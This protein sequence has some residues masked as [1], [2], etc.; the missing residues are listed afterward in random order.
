MSESLFD[1]YLLDLSFF[2]LSVKKRQKSLGSL[3][4]TWWTYSKHFLCFLKQNILF[5]LGRSCSHSLLAAYILPVG[6]ISHQG[7]WLLI[8]SEGKRTI[9]SSVNFWILKQISQWLLSWERN[10]GR[11]AE[12]KQE[13]EC[14]CTESENFAWRVI[15]AYQSHCF[16]RQKLVWV[17]FY[18]YTIFQESNH[19]IATA[20]RW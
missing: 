18:I 1:A 13:E 11:P 9:G 6:C 8:G 16:L 17:I 10:L 15:L 3:P 19:H 4:Q 12:L 7:S 20:Y 2:C 5:W 14:S